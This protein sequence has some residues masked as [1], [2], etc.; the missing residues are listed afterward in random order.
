MT[1]EQLVETYDIYST[2]LESSMLKPTGKKVQGYK[3]SGE[4]QSLCY[5]PAP[6]NPELLVH[7]SLKSQCIKYD[8]LWKLKLVGNAVLGIIRLY[9]KWKHTLSF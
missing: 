6:Q 9:F 3:V 2:C 1:S 8:G 4:F 5:F 7:P